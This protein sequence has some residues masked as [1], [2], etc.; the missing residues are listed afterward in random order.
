MISLQLALGLVCRLRSRYL[1]LVVRDAARAQDYNR[2]AWVMGRALEELKLWAGS[3]EDM[4]EQPMLKH[5]RRADFVLECDATDHALGA[6]VVKAPTGSPSA[7]ASTTAF[8]R[9]K[10]GGA[11]CSA[12]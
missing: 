9:T 2:I 7:S 12:R 3:L 11:R 8:V 5:L 6:F 4:P 10:R 1:L